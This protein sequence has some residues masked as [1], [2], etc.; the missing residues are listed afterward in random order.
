MMIHVNRLGTVRMQDENTATFNIHVYLTDDDVPT[1]IMFDRVS[2]IDRTDETASY[3]KVIDVRGKCRRMQIDALNGT[4]CSRIPSF[5][6]PVGAASLSFDSD[7]WGFKKE[8]LCVQSEVR[9]IDEI[10]EARVWHERFG[11]HLGAEAWRLT[12]ADAGLQ[13]TQAMAAEVTA[14]CRT[15]QQ[16]QAVLRS[17][18]AASKE[19][20]KRRQMKKFRDEVF[21]DTWFPGDEEEEKTGFPFGNLFVDLHTR[22]K[23]DSP[24]YGHR[25]ATDSLLEFIEYYGVVPKKILTDGAPELRGGKFVSLYNS[26]TPP[27]LL[28]R[29]PT[30]IKSILRF[31][32]RPIPAVLPVQQ[33]PNQGVDVEAGGGVGVGEEEQKDGVGGAEGIGG[34]DDAGLGGGEPNAQD[35][36]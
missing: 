33:V 29:A 14:T 32:E 13:V 15:C 20:S 22:E 6:L 26:F 17:L 27:I 8:S 16:K 31:V 34:A 4:C 24:M 2:H 5:H 9:R 3:F 25:E 12:L 7:R 30:G 1:L 18:R 21:L 36:S 11:I 23:F 28:E 35:G 19:K 10:E